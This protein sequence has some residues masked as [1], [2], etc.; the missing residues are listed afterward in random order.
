MGQSIDRTLISSAYHSD[1]LQGEWSVGETFIGYYMSTDLQLTNGFL[2][3]LLASGTSILEE[4]TRKIVVF[5]NP[6]RHRINIVHNFTQPISFEVRDLS[7]RML[8]FP[9]VAS[10]QT[11]SDLSQ[12][13][14]GCYSI[15]LLLPGN[16]SRSMLIF[17]M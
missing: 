8:T 5:P 1:A 6:F 17:K 11:T 3:G 9:K 16:T 2:Q 10:S 15:R 13:P 4:A 14:S 7:G 12:L